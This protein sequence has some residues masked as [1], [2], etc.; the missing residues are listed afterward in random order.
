MACGCRKT[1]VRQTAG[2]AWDDPTGR[3]VQRSRVVF[4]VVID[5]VDVE[6]RSLREARVAAEERGLRVESRRVRV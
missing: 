1:G 3:R 5:G 2:E 4:F 6:F